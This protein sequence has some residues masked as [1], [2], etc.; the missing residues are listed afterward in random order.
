MENDSLRQ[1]NL[2]K[3]RNRVPINKNDKNFGIPQGT[4]ISAVLA[5]IY[6]VDLDTIL[7]DYAL[8]NGGIHRRYSDDIIIVLPL[9]QI[10]NDQID[11]HISYIKSEVRKNKVDMGEDKTSTLYYANSQIFTDSQSCR[12]V[13]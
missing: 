9:E 7:N 4:A 8:R 6:A 11:E 1:Q 3:F 12:K 5:N 2:E 10:E 13:N